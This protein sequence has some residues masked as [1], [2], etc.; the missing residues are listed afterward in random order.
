M[1][2]L[3]CKNNYISIYLVFLFMRITKQQSRP[4]DLEFPE[5][6][7]KFLTKEN[8]RI[9]LIF[10]QIWKTLNWVID[11]LQVKTE[12][13][14]HTHVPISSY[15]SSFLLKVRGMSK[16]W[17]SHSGKSVISTNYTTKLSKLSLFGSK[18]N[19]KIYFGC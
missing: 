6:M 8:E 10:K 11:Y 14:Y 4:T 15:R 19:L 5:R 2:L 1:T 12:N 17:L 18:N 9:L 7:S 16:C 13:H 3:W